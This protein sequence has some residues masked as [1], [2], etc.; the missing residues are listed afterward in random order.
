M[1]RLRRKLRAV[2]G[3]FRR[4]RTLAALTATGLIFLFTLAAITAF[5]GAPA[6]RGD[7]PYP[8]IRGEDSPVLDDREAEA[9]V[10]EHLAVIAWA[11]NTTERAIGVRENGPHPFSLYMLSQ[12]DL[13]CA[14]QYRETSLSL[15]EPDLE[16]L[17]ICMDQNLA[18]RQ[19]APWQSM[20]AI[21]RE[22]R[23]RQQLRLLWASLSP[24]QAARASLAYSNRLDVDRGN[25]D[26]FRAF[27]ESF[28]VCL[29]RAEERAAVLAGEDM[30]AELAEGW[31]EAGDEMAACRDRVTESIFPVETTIEGVN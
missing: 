19:P 22:A 6:P 12:P 4:R 16:F 27:A 29:E 2:Y 30:E 26:A 3:F 21:E 10:V 13:H 17:E 7:L 24:E 18:H 23:M 25:N 5:F 14:R 8:V 15:G 20:K 9:R 31:L 1:R 11:H 28:D